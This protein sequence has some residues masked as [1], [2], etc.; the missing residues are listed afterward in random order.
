M[1]HHGRWGGRNV[2]LSSQALGSIP[3]GVKIGLA[4]GA[5]LLL[6]LVLAIG[7]LLVLLLVKLMAGGSLPSYLENVVEYFRR[8]LQPLLD[9]LK[10]LQSIAGK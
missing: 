5:L 4:V 2:H 6:L 9:V 8:N 1:G 10:S 7:V 3:R